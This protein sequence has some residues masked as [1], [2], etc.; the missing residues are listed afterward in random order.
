MHSMTVLSS[1][2]L[3][4]L[5]VHLIMG[6][7]SCKWVCDFWA[8]EPGTF[9]NRW[10]VRIFGPFRW[11]VFDL[12]NV[13]LVRWPHGLPLERLGCVAMR[14]RSV[15]V[16]ILSHAWQ[17]FG[18]LYLLQDGHGTHVVVTHDIESI[19]AFLQLLR[20]KLRRLPVG[21]VWHV[22]VGDGFEGAHV[23]EWSGLAERVG[24][25]GGVLVVV[26]VGEAVR[27]VG[28]TRL[29]HRPMVVEVLLL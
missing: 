21:N 16:A 3:V 25:P 9:E 4:R 28:R 18:V 19:Q 12:N 2:M 5:V 8:R 26:A 11:I 17:H 27:A 20:R 29:V 1:K 15:G 13:D 14:R 7:F 24:F 23:A 6:C 22:M 10:S